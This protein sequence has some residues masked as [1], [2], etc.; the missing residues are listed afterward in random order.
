[1]ASTPADLSDGGYATAAAIT[2]AMALALTTSALTGL[3]AVKLRGA[4]S[5]LNRMR[6]EHVL[7]S[8][9]QEA[10]GAVMANAKSERLGWSVQAGGAQVQI[11]A[12]PEAAKLGYDGAA[13]LDEKMLTRLGVKD[14]GALRARLAQ[15]AAAT[16]GDYGLWPG[17]LDEAPGWRSCAGSLLSA[18]GLAKTPTLAAP[19]APDGRGVSWRPGEVWKIE[20]AASGWA[21]TALVRFTGDGQR[22]AA[23]I[24]RKLARQTEGE[25]SCNLQLAT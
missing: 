1:M 23:V 3:A 5:D 9:R 20:A 18:F 22:P 12:E 15:A 6:L 2:F 14:A 21:E 4:R 8:A 17:E 16:D 13:K 10:I 24:A 11:L 25:G 19:A 7:A